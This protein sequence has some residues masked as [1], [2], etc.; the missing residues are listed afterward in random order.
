[1]VLPKL[2]IMGFCKLNMEYDLKRGL[3]WYLPQDT[4]WLCVYKGLTEIQSTL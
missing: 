2:N 3:D 1:M 4:D